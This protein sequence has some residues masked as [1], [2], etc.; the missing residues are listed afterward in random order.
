[1]KGPDADF[2]VRARSFWAP[3]G[4]CPAQPLES[5]LGGGG[6]LRLVNDET[7]LTIGAPAEWTGLTVKA[8][9][10]YADRGAD[11]P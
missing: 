4:L 11:P 6:R 7:I 2:C 1:M 3:R 9:R 8:I 5:P 10:F